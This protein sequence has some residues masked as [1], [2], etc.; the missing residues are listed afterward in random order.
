MALS[1]L[2]TLTFRPLNGVTGYP[3]HGLLPA[4]FQL[5]TPFHAQ[6]RIRHETERQSDRQTDNDGHQYI[7]LHP[8]RVESYYYYYYYYY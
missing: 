5:P 8:K 1:G 3:S 2:V 7:I 4:N 6:L